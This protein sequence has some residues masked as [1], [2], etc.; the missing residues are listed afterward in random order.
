MSTLP[1]LMTKQL[2]TIP[3]DTLISEAARQMQEAKVG[4]MLVEQNGNITGIVTDTDIV[5][6]VVAK[7]LD[8][9]KTTVETIMTTPLATIES[10]RSVQDAQ[11]MMAD[12]GVRHLVVAESGKIVGL[13]SVRD[14]L[15]YFQ[16]VSEPKI[17]V[18]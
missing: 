12:L 17:T 8:P 15:V 5:R 6:K 13:V 3:A 9:T 7:D 14:L 2:R 11:D 16:R 1:E 18:D 4:A 10:Y